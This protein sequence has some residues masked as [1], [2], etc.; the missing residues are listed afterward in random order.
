[1]IDDVEVKRIKEL[2]PR[3]IEHEAGARVP[4]T[5]RFELRNRAIRDGVAVDSLLVA[6]VREIARHG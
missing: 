6:E 5:R 2:S 1:M 3:D 4:G